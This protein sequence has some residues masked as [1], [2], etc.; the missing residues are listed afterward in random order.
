LIERAGQVLNRDQLLDLTRGRTAGPFDR[1][2]DNQISRLRR[3]IE[4]D[5]KDP[6]Y[7]KTIWGGGYRF[8]TEVRRG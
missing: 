7:I 2:I 5:P 6:T 3:K 1:A 4:P 8:S